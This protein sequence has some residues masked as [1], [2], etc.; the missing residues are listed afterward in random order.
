MRHLIKNNQHEHQTVL[1]DKDCYLPD[2]FPNRH[3][4]EDSRISIFVTNS[5]NK[6]NLNPDSYDNSKEGLFMEHVDK[7]QKAE[8]FS[9]IQAKLESFNNE[10]FI[11]SSSDTSRNYL[12]NVFNSSPNQDQSHS[13]IFE[14]E[15]YNF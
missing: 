15:L 2:I 3:S 7:F 11:P 6:E 10:L 12:I 1:K 14:N 9:E 8:Q 13:S 5:E 4:A